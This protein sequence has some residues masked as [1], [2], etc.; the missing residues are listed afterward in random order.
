MGGPMVNPPRRFSDKL[1]PKCHIG[2]GAQFFLNAQQLI[3]LHF[4]QIETWIPFYRLQ[5]VATARS[6]MVASS[7]ST[8]VGHNHAKLGPLRHMNGIVSDKVDLVYFDMMAL[9]EAS[10]IPRSKRLVLVT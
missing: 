6:A 1:S 8:A 9:P 5:L 7:V 10:A 2:G 3:V 4:G